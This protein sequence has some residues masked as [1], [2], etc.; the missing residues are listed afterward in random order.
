MA[1]VDVRMSASTLLAAFGA[2]VA[3]GS[4]WDRTAAAVLVSCHGHYHWSPLS[5]CVPASVQEYVESER[6][7]VRR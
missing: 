3:V 6:E 4:S 2:T 7:S 5:V 1:M